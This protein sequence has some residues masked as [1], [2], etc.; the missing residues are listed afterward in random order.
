MKLLL[1]DLRLRDRRDLLKDLLETAIPTT[2]QDVI[3]VFA[4][5]SGLPTGGWCSI[6]I[7]HVSWARPWRATPPSAIQLTTAASIC[8]ALGRWPRAVCRKKG[9]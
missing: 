1:N 7:Q 4:T 5:A 3:V 9:L 8:T 6:R 2:D